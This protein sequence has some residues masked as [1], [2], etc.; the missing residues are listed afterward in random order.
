M[1]DLDLTPGEAELV[2]EAR[3]DEI[4]MAWTLIHLGIKRNDGTDPPRPTTSD[5]DRAF[6]SLERLSRAGLI[7]VGHTAYVDGG[8]P[9]RAAPV[10]VVEDPLSEV[11]QRVLTA[12]R[13]GDDN[14]W[15]FELWLTAT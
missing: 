1:S 12:I 6:E 15:Q 13:D 4:D 5:I 14:G 9:G 2:E 3:R 7:R 11:K 8:P 10:N